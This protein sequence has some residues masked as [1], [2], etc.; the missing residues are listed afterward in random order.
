MPNRLRRNCRAFAGRVSQG[1]TVL[2]PEYGPGRSWRWP[3]R[4]KT[5]EHDSIRHG[6]P[7]KVILGP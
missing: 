6:R 5:D 3:D 2:H 4:A 7:E 1:M